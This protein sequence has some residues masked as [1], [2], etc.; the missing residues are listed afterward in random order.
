MTLRRSIWRILNPENRRLKL[1]INNYIEVRC[2]L[3]ALQAWRNDV[4]RSNAVPLWKE[5]GEPFP[6]LRF[7]DLSMKCFNLMRLGL[8]ACPI[9]RIQH[10]LSRRK[11]LLP[12]LGWKL[13]LQ[14]FSHR[15]I[16]PNYVLGRQICATNQRRMYKRLASKRSIQLA[17]G[18]H[19]RT[20]C[21]YPVLNET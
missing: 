16:K 10:F 14:L 1:V 2:F 15:V 5:T 21:F 7:G 6:Q 18:F 4:P 9:I 13:D 19:G 8:F 17:V 3:R 20:R 12:T 11:K